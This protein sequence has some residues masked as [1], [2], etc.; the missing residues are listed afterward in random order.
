MA[1]KKDSSEEKI[2]AA[3]YIINFY[4]EV[5]Q[6]LHNHAQY[7]NLLRKLEYQMNGIDLSKMSIEER[8]VLIQ[9]IESTFYYVERVYTRYM[10]LIEHISIPKDKGITNIYQ[11]ISK[12]YVIRKEDLTEFVI[13]MNNVLI[14]STMKNL[15]E[16]SQEFIDKM[17]KDE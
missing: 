4:T 1:K 7:K 14:K 12:N 3:N 16:T 5:E 13:K 6:L 10:S 11:E 15:L 9:A 17:Y 2:A 8:N